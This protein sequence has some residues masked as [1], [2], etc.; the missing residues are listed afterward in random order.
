MTRAE[1]WT[2]DRQADGTFRV[3]DSRGRIVCVVTQERD[4]RL[5]AAAPAVADFAARAR[6][7]LRDNAND[8]AY[9]L[10]QLPDLPLENDTTS[11]AAK[12]GGTI[13]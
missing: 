1:R 7:V 13:Q 12:K 9:L 10:K 11:T 2:W 4:A 6:R 3:K 8:V 5:I